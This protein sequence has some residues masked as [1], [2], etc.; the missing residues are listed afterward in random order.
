LLAAHAG[1][2]VDALI[3][4][5]AVG[6]AAGTLTFMLGTASEDAVERATAALRIM[7]AR[8]AYIGG[9]GAGLLAKLPNNYLLAAANVATCEAMRLGVASGLDLARLAALVSAL[10]GRRWLA[11]VN[12][13]VPGVVLGAP[14]GRGYEGGFAVRL[15]EKDLR[16][17]LGVAREAGV[18]TELGE[19]VLQVYDKVGKTEM[20]RLDFSVVYR[21]LEEGAK[22]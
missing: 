8:V 6:A 13:S 10:S 21:W 19:K 22:L 11:D 14:A 9:L 7:G 4:G 15:I 1:T 12:N 20:A 18:R 17:A 3:S 16:L 5:G 2:F